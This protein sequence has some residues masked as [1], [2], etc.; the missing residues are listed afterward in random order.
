MVKKK[1]HKVV[2]FGLC[3][4]CAI[5]LRSNRLRNRVVGCGKFH[6]KFLA[7]KKKNASVDCVEWVLCVTGMCEDV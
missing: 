3:K 4:K 1:G 7:S 5:G 6:K 2:T